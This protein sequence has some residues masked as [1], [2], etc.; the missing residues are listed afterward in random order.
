[1]SFERERRSCRLLEPLTGF[2]S[3]STNQGQT[4]SAK[5]PT[6]SQA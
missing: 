2:V 1:M 3:A 6:P 4:G 5:S